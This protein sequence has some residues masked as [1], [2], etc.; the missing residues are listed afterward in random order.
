MKNKL[1]IIVNDLEMK[2]TIE[3]LYP[4]ET[5]LGNIIIETLDREHVD[6]QGY[7]L[8]SKGAR[9]IIGRS[10]TYD[11]SVGNVSVPLLR[12][13]VTTSDVFSA[14]IKGLEFKKRWL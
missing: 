5:Q 14:L 9:V 2:N 12:L 13:K 4:Q 3:E 7:R 6:E 10:G 11:R 1:G 8:E